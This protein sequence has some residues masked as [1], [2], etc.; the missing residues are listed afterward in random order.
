MPSRRLEFSIVQV[1]FNWS[2]GADLHDSRALE[3]IRIDVRCTVLKE[4]YAVT[5]NVMFAM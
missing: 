4:I 5:A 2:Q 3:F 1:A